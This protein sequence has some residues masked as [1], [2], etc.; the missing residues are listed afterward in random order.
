[1][2]RINGKSMLYHFS[3]IRSKVIQM[4]E[5]VETVDGMFDSFDRMTELGQTMI[6]IKRL[7]KKRK[8]KKDDGNYF[9]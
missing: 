4:R 3:G 6:P 1:M 5:L 7:E 9:Y 8:P 2:V